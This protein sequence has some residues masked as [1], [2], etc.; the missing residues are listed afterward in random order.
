MTRA[1]GVRSPALLE[2]VH[3][4][5]HLVERRLHGVEARR[6][7]MREI[8]FGG[9]ARD[10]E[11]GDERADRFERAA[12]D[13]ER[14]SCSSVAIRSADTDVV[15]LLHVHPQRVEDR[16]R[17]RRAALHRSTMAAPQLLDAPP[18]RLELGGQRGRPRVELGRRFLEALD[19]GGETR[20]ALD[21]RGVR[22]ARFGGAPAQILG[23]LARFEQAPLRQRQ[24]LVG[25]LLLV[26][27]ADDRR[28]RLVLT[29]IERLA[30]L[31]GLMPLARELF[32]LQ[33]ETRR[34][35]A[36][37]L[38]LRLEA[39][40]GLFLFV[41]LGVQRGDGVRRR[42]RSSPSSAAVSSASRDERVPLDLNPLAQL[43]DFALRLENAAR[44]VPAAA[45]DEVR[46]AEDVAV[47]RSRPA[48]SSGGSPPGAARTNR[49]S[50]R[51]RS[52]GGWRPANGPFTR[53]I[54]DSATR[55]SGQAPG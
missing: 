19:F 43:L 34:L 21:H 4:S 14:A 42:S 17:R 47:R 51:R 2:L 8:A 13:L 15:G 46:T 18:R 31:F 16:A 10:V 53:T 39:D 33:R 49:R 30:L 52:R 22:G 5:A 48:A 28:A 6:R 38:Q 32:A 20:G 45:G 24:P 3:F 44:V 40:D 36:R 12:R 26:L 37:V 7:E 29:A 25:Q 11:L 27:Q 54:D 1:S 35:V 41:M 9:R 55:P 23:R 50:T